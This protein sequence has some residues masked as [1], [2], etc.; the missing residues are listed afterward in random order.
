MT[1]MSELFCSETAK[2]RITALERES[3]ERGSTI[4]LFLDRLVQ[5]KRLQNHLRISFVQEPG[6]P[7]ETLMF[8][9]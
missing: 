9:T 8:E 3:Q 4:S 2:S 7:S 5:Q 1:E 6:D